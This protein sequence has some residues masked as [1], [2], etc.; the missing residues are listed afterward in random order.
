MREL[1]NLRLNLGE[2]HAREIALHSIRS[3]LGL[4]HEQTLLGGFAKPQPDSLSILFWS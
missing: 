2:E 4:T 3:E 1:F